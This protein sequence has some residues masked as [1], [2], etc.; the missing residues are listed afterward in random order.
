MAEYALSLNRSSGG[1]DFSKDRVVFHFPGAPSAMWLILSSLIPELHI[2]NK[3]FVRN[4]NGFPFL[5]FFF[6]FV[7]LRSNPG[8]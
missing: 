8:L 7:M 5:F 4:V 2:G 6:F 1:G 3:D